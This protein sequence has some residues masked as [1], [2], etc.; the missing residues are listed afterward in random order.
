M[1]LEMAYRVKGIRQPSEMQ[2]TVP[3]HIIVLQ[4]DNDDD[5]IAFSDWWNEY[6]WMDFG[7][8]VKNAQ[9]NDGAYSW[10]AV[11]DV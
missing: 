10:T 11:E 2:L 9:E 5:A 3:E 6:G 1:G 4:F 8:Y 7:A